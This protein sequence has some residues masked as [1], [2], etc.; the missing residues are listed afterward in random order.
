MFR[1]FSLNTRSS[2]TEET[3][4]VGSR[5]TVQSHSRSFDV[6]TDRKPVCD[7]LLVNIS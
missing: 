1:F 5:Y 2:T 3:A 4:R 7:F 6:G